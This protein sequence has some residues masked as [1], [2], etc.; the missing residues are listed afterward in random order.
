MKLIKAKALLQVDH[1]KLSPSALQ[2]HKVQMLDAWRYAKGDY[3]HQNDFFVSVPEL[4]AYV[5]ADKWILRNIENKLNELG[6]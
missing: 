6:L 5:P 1:T 3:G 4:R 2:N